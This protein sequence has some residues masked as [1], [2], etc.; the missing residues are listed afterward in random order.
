MRS[1]IAIVKLTLRSAMRSHIFQLLLGL[2]ILCVALVPTTVGGSTAM[3][4]IRVSLLYSLSSVA[5]ILSLSALWVGCHVMSSDIDDYRLHMVVSKPVSRVTIWFGKWMGVLLLHLFLLVIAAAAI[6]GVVMWRFSHGNFSKAERTRIRLEVL[7]GRRVFMPE[8]RDYEKLARERLKA[9]LGIRCPQCGNEEALH[10]LPGS[11]KKCPKCGKEWVFRPVPP[12]REQDRL[13]KTCLKELIAED[14]EVVPAYYEVTLPDGSKDIKFSESK[15]RTWDFKNVPPDA[16]R[17]LYLRYRPFVGKVRSEEQRE[18][19][20]GWFIYVPR[21]TRGGAQDE[22][23]RDQRYPFYLPPTKVMG[24]EFHEIPLRG[25]VGIVSPNGEVRIGVYDL[26]PKYSKHFYQPGDGPKL[27][28]EVTSFLGN[29]ARAVLV[30]GLQLVMMSLLSCAFGGFL[31]L[32]TAVFVST[33]YLVFGYMASFMTD[34][35]YYVSSEIDE[36]GQGISRWLLNVIVPL[37]R[38]DVTDLVAS[39]ELVEWALVWN[40]AW[41]CLLLRTLPW[42]L[43]GIYLYWRREIGLEIKK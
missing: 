40:I 3:D 27:L 7:V 11:Q 39:G 30:L 38:F 34:P 26:D 20:V 36:A 6:Y 25:D 8:R 37:E 14:S 1:F 16:T 10:T 42:V 35:G 24:G 13:L 43:G 12:P 33:S 31:T 17:A 9:K 23:G 29:Y 21:V 4:F 18:T 2:L 41:S 28:I 15:F 32:P 5:T 19:A 22:S